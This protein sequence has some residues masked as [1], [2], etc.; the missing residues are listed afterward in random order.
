MMSA[1]SLERAASNP[2]VA[3]AGVPIR[4][5]E[6]TIGG[7]GSNGTALRFTVMP[8]RVQPVLGLLAVQLGVAQVDQH[9]VHVGA[10]GSTEI[11][12]RGDVGG[13]EPVG[14]DPRALE[15]ALLPLA[16]TPRS[17]RHLERHRLGGD[18]VLQRAALLAGEDRAS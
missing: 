7:R 13:R 3:S 6:E 10:A 4:R 1:T 15:R 5:P 11:A 16:G 9:Q 2:R 14:E 8:M 17:A 18:H 12:G